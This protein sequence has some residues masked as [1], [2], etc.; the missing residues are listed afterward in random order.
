MEIKNKSDINFEYFVTF[1]LSNGIINCK[2]D[3]VTNIPGTNNG[4]VTLGINVELSDG[5]GSNDYISFSWV[6]KDGINSS[7]SC[8]KPYYAGSGLQHDK[9]GKLIMEMVPKHI[10]LST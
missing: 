5:N 8:S 4:N 10:I 2:C 6:M 3:S 7:K 9:V 1:S